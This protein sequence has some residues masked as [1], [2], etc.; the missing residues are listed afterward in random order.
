MHALTTIEQAADFID[1]VGFALLFPADRI[2]AP[3]LYEVVK[4]ADVEPFAEGS[5]ES[6]IWGWK[7]ELPKDGRVWYGKFAYKRAS[8]LCPELLAALYPADGDL[9]DH[10]HLDLSPAAHR[11]ADA[12]VTGPLP[13]PA[14]RELVGDKNAYTR[15]IT[16][17][18]RALLV[19]TAGVH[20]QRS[21][22]PAAI[23][24]LT[25]RRFEV[26]RGGDRA[27]ATKRYVDAVDEPSPRDLSRAF[28]WPLAVARRELADQLG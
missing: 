6:M 15:G 12:L 16:E 9:D 11:I 18:Q 23:V 1:E 2:D 22:W 8:L 19:T 20:E 7:D 26:G 17:L 28:N 10:E 5:V 21:G 25:C 14:L 24:E 4:G 13:T 3:T 27:Y